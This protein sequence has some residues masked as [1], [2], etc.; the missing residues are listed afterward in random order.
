MKAAIR[1]PNPVVVLENELLY[2]QQWSYADEVVDKDFTIEFGKAKIERQGTDVTLVAYARGVQ[3]CLEGAKVL[4]DEYGIS[5]EVRRIKCRFGHCREA[6]CIA[7][8]ALCPARDAI[9]LVACTAFPCPSTYLYIYLSHANAPPAPQVIN[10]RSIRPLDREAIVESVKKTNRLVTVEE[11]FPQSGVG[12][13]IC[14]LVMESEAFDYLDA[15]VERL[16]GADVPMPYAPNLEKS[17]MPHKDDVVTVARR[18]C[19]KAL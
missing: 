1:D 11:G 6:G 3:H 15:P 17:A 14:A 10:L 19:G 8:R 16:T 18:V 2:G 13:E 4:Q 12:S 5:A 9:R 7:H